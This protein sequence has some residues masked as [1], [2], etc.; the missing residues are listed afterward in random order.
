MKTPSALL[1]L[2][3]WKPKPKQNSLI[4]QIQ[5]IIIFVSELGIRIEKPF[6]ILPIGIIIYI[7]LY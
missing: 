6:N 5:Q 7:L 1:K 4:N 2:Q 3:L